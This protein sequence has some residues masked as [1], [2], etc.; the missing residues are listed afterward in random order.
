MP[1]F[2]SELQISS[3]KSAST[4]NAGVRFSS[5][6][7]NLVLHVGDDNRV[8]IGTDRPEA[9]LHVDG[10]L[11]ATGLIVPPGTI[12]SASDTAK[13]WGFNP[14]FD[15]WAGAV[16]NGYTQTGTGVVEQSSDAVLG[17]SSARF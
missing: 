16:A 14:L 11:I 1:K 2:E 7:N 8:G 4:T 12:S 9:T 15:E 17:G 5:S 6:S 3:L 13:F 10:T